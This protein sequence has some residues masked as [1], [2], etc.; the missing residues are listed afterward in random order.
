MI[1]SLCS[2]DP[3]DRLG[4][5]KEGVNGI[6]KH[7]WFEGFDWE[8]L[9]TEAIK[10]PIIPPIKNPFDASNFSKV[11]ETDVKKIPDETSGWDDDF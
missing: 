3:S 2:T 6:R 8:A 9:Q 7:R 1:K 10:A 11:Q 5:Q 4:Y